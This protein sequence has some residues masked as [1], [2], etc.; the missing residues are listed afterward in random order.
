MFVSFCAAVSITAETFPLIMDIPNKLICSIVESPIFT[1]EMVFNMSERLIVA[2]T[3]NSLVFTLSPNQSFNGTNV[4]C[5]ATTNSGLY[6][7]N[8]ITVWVQ[9]NSHC[10]VLSY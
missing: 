4:T 3:T 5:T 2:N 6:F 8:Y 1:M 7:E 9:G 10:S